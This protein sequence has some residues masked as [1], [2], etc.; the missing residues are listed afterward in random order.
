[1]RLHVLPLVVLLAFPGTAAATEWFVQPG[2][3]GPGT[4]TAPFGRIQDALNA[5]RP[6]DQVSVFRGTYSESL[7]TVR[8]GSVEQPI[9]IRAAEGRGSVIVSTRQTVLIVR[10]AHHEV[11]GLVIDAQ[12]ALADA[13]VVRNGGHFFVLRNAEVRRTSRDAIDLAAP[14]G[15]LIENSLIHHAL[16]AARGR[17]DAHGIVAGPVRRLTIR[18]TE[19]H[20]F[21]GDAI[22]MDPGRAAPGW[23]DVT[24]EGCRLWLRPLP[25]PENGFP[26]GTV[27]GE[28][29]VDTKALI[30]L[31]RA[32]IVIRDTVAFG[33]RGG[34][35]SNMAAFNLKE[36]IDALVDGVTVYDSEIAFRIRGGGKGRAGALAGIRNAV[37]H[38]TVTAFRYEDAIENLRVWNATIGGGVVRAFLA[39]SA[40]ATGMEVRN[41]L[42]LGSTLPPEASHPSNLITGA[43]AFVNAA[44]HD[45]SLVEGARAVDAGVPLPDVRSDRRGTPRPQG[46]GW[47]AGAYELSRRQ[48]SP[49]WN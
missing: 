37:V 31:P 5:A 9:R 39:G 3:T 38:S 19:I 10:H 28:N 30:G 46:R 21:S 1:M 32:R 17:T 11:D 6:G 26:A 41:L 47:D 36:N 13:I 42:V 15:V 43:K 20:T 22:Q 18:G 34:L 29:G 44:A 27:P 40:T 12:Y 49:R 23:T 4:R 2:G 25:A 16:N 14:E 8:D 45:Y 24:I 35:I 48:T 7:V 33:F